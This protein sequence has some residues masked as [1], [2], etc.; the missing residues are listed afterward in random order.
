MSLEPHTHSGAS[1]QHHQQPSS[2]FKQTEILYDKNAT[3]VE[4][5]HCDEI[6]KPKKVVIKTTLYKK[7][8]FGHITESRKWSSTNTIPSPLRHCSPIPDE[9]FHYTPKPLTSQ[10]PSTLFADNEV[11]S[12][13]GSKTTVGSPSFA[14]TTFSG[15][16]STQKINCAPTPLRSFDFNLL[17]DDQEDCPR[18]SNPGILQ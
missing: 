16:P 11:A 8:N 2:C 4:H 15:S 5:F 14:T 9:E 18:C 17:D 1:F 6:Q 10:S 12:I 13:L 3:S 7:P